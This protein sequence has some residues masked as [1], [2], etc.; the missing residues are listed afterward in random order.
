MSANEPEGLPSDSPAFRLNFIGIESSIPSNSL[1]IIPPVPRR[2]DSDEDET[3]SS[4]RT[5]DE[6]RTRASLIDSELAAL[7]SGAELGKLLLDRAVVQGGLD[8]ISYPVLTLPFEITSKIFRSTLGPKD[9]NPSTSSY[10]A[11]QRAS[12]R[13]GHICRVWREIA[14]A[15]RELWTT[16]DLRITHPSRRIL[17]S[18]QAL[19]RAFLSRAASSPLHVSLSGDTNSVRAILELLAPYSRTWGS[20][21]FNCRRLM[22]MKV[23][24]SIRH[25]L[26][27]LTSLRLDL[28]MAALED[29]NFRD[30]F[31]DAPLLRTVY[32][33]SFGSQESALPWAQ[34]T[35]LT[36]DNCSGDSFAQILGWTANLVHLGVGKV[37]S[38]GF[39]DVVVMPN[40]RSVT[41]RDGLPP[42]E[43]AI[44]SHLDAHL[45]VLKLWTFTDLAAF[46]RPMRHPSS[47]AEFSVDIIANA[48]VAA[49]SIECLTPMSS[50]RILKIIA[51]DY[52]PASTNFSLVPLV[53][54]LLNDATFLPKL[55][56]LTIIT[57]YPSPDSAS[58]FDMDTLSNMLSV[59]FPRGLRHFELRSHRAVPAI[60][61]R[62]V[63]LRANG[64]Q[65][66]LE[67]EPGLRLDPFRDEF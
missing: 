26:P 55:E 32:L 56:S 60:D 17:E 10:L 15:T 27:A 62:G 8:A 5:H 48:K 65:I 67:T 58:E 28:G 33:R 39:H 36:L 41:F 25:Q 9:A 18:H 23:L 63:D 12:L 22:D 7:P 50:L 59:R 47:L 57:L 42:S 49:P 45:R 61:P 24:Q 2:R 20:I 11:S 64:M 54:R 14:L 30:M 19:V 3:L 44:L 52:D 43:V 34:L 38:M 40:L 35:S 21:D 16:L 1:D 31:N 66:V 4:R 29:G 37:G 13:L 51:Y 53:V 46:S 6:L